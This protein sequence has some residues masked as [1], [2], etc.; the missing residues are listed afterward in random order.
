MVLWWL[1]NTRCRDQLTEAT[2]TVDQRIVT[3]EWL[4][5]IPES[6]SIR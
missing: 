1:I 4:K 6:G 2:A 3:D 5:V